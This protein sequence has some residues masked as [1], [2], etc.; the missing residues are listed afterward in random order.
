MDTCTDND[1]SSR[2]ASTRMWRESH[3]D[4]IGEMVLARD[5][6]G[7]VVDTTWDTVGFF[8]GGHHGC[9]GSFDSMRRPLPSSA[10]LAHR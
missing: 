5:F 1:A 4:L 8:A 9:D 2:D 6:R 7:L 3:E 10:L